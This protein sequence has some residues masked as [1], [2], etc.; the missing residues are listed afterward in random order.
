M[1]RYVY[2]CNICI[3]IYI[4]VSVCRYIYT[5]ICVYVCVFFCGLF[6]HRARSLVVSD[7]HSETKG[8]RFESSH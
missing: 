2:V 5:G 8:S 6:L 4:C 1:Y 7:L 3:Y